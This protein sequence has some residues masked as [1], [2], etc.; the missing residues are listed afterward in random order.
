MERGMRGERGGCGKR[1]W[2]GELL[3]QHFP[4]INL[5]LCPSAERLQGVVRQRK[6]VQL[7]HGVLTPTEPWKTKC[8][9]GQKTGLRACSS[10]SISNLKMETQNIKI[11][12]LP[13]TC[14][15]PSLTSS[16]TCRGWHQGHRQGGHRCPTSHMQTGTSHSDR[17]INNRLDKV[18]CFIRCDIYPIHINPIRPLRL[19]LPSK[20]EGFLK[21]FGVNWINC[22][23]GFRNLR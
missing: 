19:K 16:I 14:F 23:P 15:L 7:F 21:T 9:P 5:V 3:F 12:F 6:A 4:Q 22:G 18:P 8:L 10:H 2:L 17:K 13:V 20:K 11:T 1:G